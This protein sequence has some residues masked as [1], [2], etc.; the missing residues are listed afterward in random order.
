MMG[1]S[2]D[3]DEKCILAEGYDVPN[4][5]HPG[6]LRDA[7]ALASITERNSSMRSGLISACTTTANLRK[8][9][10]QVD[11]A[12]ALHRPNW[13]TYLNEP[14]PSKTYGLAERDVVMLRWRC[15]EAVK[16]GN[17]NTLFDKSKQ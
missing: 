17:A 10:K 15:V 3:Y 16:E 12:L 1:L 14:F 4:L 2:I 5:K 11:L 7:T 13:R 8:G 6:S 9:R